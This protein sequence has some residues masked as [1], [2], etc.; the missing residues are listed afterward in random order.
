MSVPLCPCGSQLAYAECCEPYL[1]GKATAPTAERLMRSRYTAYIKGNV[2]YLIATRHPSTR[3]RGDRLA[4]C[5]TMQT[6]RWVGLTVLKTQ[7]GKSTDD[8]GIVEFVALYQSADSGLFS[9]LEL[10]M[11]LSLNEG[12]VQ[13]LHERSRFV[14]E[15]GQ[16]TYVDGDMLPPVKLNPQP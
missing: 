2:N 16:W 9:S 11:P 1:M 3:Q 5:Q 15:N 10:A 14:K 13:Q 7:R 4:L 6:T 8:Q 12:V